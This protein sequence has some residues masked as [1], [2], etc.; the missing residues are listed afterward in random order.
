VE[1]I[2]ATHDKISASAKEGSKRN[3]MGKENVGKENGERKIGP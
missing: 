2:P 3:K 1:A